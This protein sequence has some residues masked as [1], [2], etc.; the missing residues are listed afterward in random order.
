MSTS[1]IDRSCRAMLYVMLIRLMYLYRVSSVLLNYR[2]RAKKN[3]LAK[4]ETTPAINF[5]EF[6]EYAT[7][8]EDCH[9]SEN[10]VYAHG[11]TST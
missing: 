11:V 7:V 10:I 6:H 3:K 8:N 4:E 1:L 2:I 9:Q 5:K